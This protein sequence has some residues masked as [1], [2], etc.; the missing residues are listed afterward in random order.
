LMKF[1]RSFTDPAT[2]FWAGFW[3]VIIEAALHY[4]R[5]MASK[6]GILL[7][8]EGGLFVGITFGVGVAFAALF[9]VVQNLPFALSPG[10][11]SLSLNW[12]PTP[13]DYAIA[14]IVTLA[15]VI[16]SVG[17][18]RSALTGNSEAV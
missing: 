1:R 2:I 3:A 11:T 9:P 18:I 6:R 13:L 8:A 7:V 5:I 4:K 17:V 15:T 14:G 10:I 12:P 16:L